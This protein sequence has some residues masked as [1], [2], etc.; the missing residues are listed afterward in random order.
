M[1]DLIAELAEVVRL[2]ER[3]TPGEWCSTIGYHVKQIG[4]VIVM[5]PCERRGDQQMH[6]AEYIAALSNLFRNNHATLTRILTDDAAIR[7]A[8][9]E[10]VIRLGEVTT[11]LEAA[12]R[13]AERYRFIRSSDADADQPY[14]ARH[15]QTDWGKFYDQWLMEDD[16]DNAI[17]AA[18][19]DSA[20]EGND[21]A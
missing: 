18:M 5:Q 8:H 17:D 14:V 15:G 16:A 3:A 1:T 13:D 20:R 12:K 2:S 19:H 6:N 9:T 4:G 11:K 10:L 21:N 7:A